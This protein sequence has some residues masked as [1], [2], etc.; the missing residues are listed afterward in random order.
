MQN[1]ELKGEGK[2]V[3]L[4]P[5]PLGIFKDD[6]Y[7]NKKDD[8]L[9]M[10]LDERDNDTSGRLISNRGGGWQSKSK[11]FFEEKNKS[12]YEYLHKM[13]ESLFYESFD[14]SG[15]LT[16]SVPNCWININPSGAYNLSH[17]HPGCDYA[18]VLYVNLPENDDID[19]DAPIVFDGPNSHIFGLT[20]NMYSENYVNA[21]GLCAEIEVYP[22]EGT[23]LIFHS[24]LRHL[25]EENK[26]KEERISIAFNIIIENYG[27]FGDNNK[28]GKIKC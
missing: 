24:S 27:R 16:F 14:H 25:V 3:P 21:Y 28:R 13:I 22:S 20:F 19:D 18:G 2:F 5:T 17:T 4:F 1:L 6:D 7:P 26:S 12:F 9:K 8:I 23:L 11:W 10:C 15:E